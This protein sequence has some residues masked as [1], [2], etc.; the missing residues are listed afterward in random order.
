M[1]HIHKVARLGRVIDTPAGRRSIVGISPGCLCR[2]DGAVPGW[3]GAPDW[4][5]GVGVAW[6]DGADVHLEV[7]EIRDG[8]LMYEGRALRGEE[9]A[10]E[11]AEATGY[12]AILAP[13]TT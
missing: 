4:Q 2:N 11:I 8:V 9:R 6:R 1:G 10:A 3:P 13:A 7:R 5:Q 12:R